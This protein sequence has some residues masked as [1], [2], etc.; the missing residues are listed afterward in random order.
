[1]EKKYFRHCFRAYVARESK[2]FCQLWALSLKDE[3]DMLLATVNEKD[4]QVIRSS[5]FYNFPWH[6]QHSGD[7][8][9]MLTTVHWKKFKIDYATQSGVEYERMT[10]P[11]KGQPIK[12]DMVAKVK[13]YRKM[14]IKFRDIAKLLDSDV[15]TVFRWNAYRLSTVK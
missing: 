6:V 8:L 9:I 13:K 2:G 1:M 5:D 4:E 7:R 12:M 10:K 15:K 11:K 14:G 3:E